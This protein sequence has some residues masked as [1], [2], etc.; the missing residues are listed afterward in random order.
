MARKQTKTRLGELDNLLGGQ[1]KSEPKSKEPER[2]VVQPESSRSDNQKTISYRLG[3]HTKERV[4][5]VAKKHDVQ[6]SDLVYF[7]LHHA[8]DQLEAGQITLPKIENTRPKKL[9]LR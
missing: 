1:S 6:K 8:L 2:K 4:N 5:E 3:I 9:G 7:L